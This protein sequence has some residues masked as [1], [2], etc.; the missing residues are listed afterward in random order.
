MKT[1]ELF[2]GLFTATLMISPL[3]NTIQ[4]ANAAQGKLEGSTMIANY[5][6]QTIEKRINNAIQKS[7]L[8]SANRGAF[9]KNLVHTAFYSL[10][11]KYN[12]MVFNLEQPYRQTLEGVELYKHAKWG[13][14][15][16]G[17]WIFEK[18]T[19]TNRGDG[20]HINWGFQGNW[21]RKGKQG[22]HVIFR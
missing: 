19:F 2:F 7:S 9:V 3:A 22:K 6:G 15:T 10:G 14:T 5:P 4:P 13:G 18:G 8:S 17:I 16:Y 1:K 20:G 11:G 12:V 21:R